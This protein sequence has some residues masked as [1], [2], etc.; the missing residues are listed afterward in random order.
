[1]NYIQQARAVLDGKYKV[2]AYSDGVILDAV[3]TEVDN[4]LAGI[5][6]RAVAGDP[7]QNFSPTSYFLRTPN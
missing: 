3:L 4:Q 5:H 2:G 7:K 6:A 1:M